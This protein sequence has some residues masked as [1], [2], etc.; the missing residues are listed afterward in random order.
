MSILQS[1][2]PQKEPPSLLLLPHFAF[3][4]WKHLLQGSYNAQAMILLGLDGK[5]NIVAYQWNT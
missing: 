5:S 4:R 3:G 1:K 2:N